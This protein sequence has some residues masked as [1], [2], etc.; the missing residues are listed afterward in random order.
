LSPLSKVLLSVALK[1]IKY[2][3][4]C[5]NYFAVYLPLFFFFLGCSGKDTIASHSFLP[6]FI[7]LECAELVFIVYADTGVKTERIYG[8]NLQKETGN[9][10]VFMAVTLKH[11][12]VWVVTPCSS[13]TTISAF[14]MLLLVS[15]VL[16]L[17]SEDG[18]D[19]FL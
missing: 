13:E 8:M 9:N 10:Q 2:A 3:L 7:I 1:V 16:F 17:Y 15:C 19:M 6:A 14:F 18:C 12:Y 11:T 5:I 4:K